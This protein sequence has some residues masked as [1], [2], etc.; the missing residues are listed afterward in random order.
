MQTELVLFIIFQILVIFHLFYP[1]ILSSFTF[2]RRR[3]KNI[4][5]PFIPE[6]DYAIIVTAYEQVN[7]IPAVVNSILH[8]NYKNYIIYVV[9]DKCDI[10]SLHFSDEKV[11]ILK[12]EATLANNIKSHFYAIENF[13]RQHDRLTIIDSDNLV[14]S[15]YL[16]ELNKTFS[17]GYD[18][19]QGIR[20]A[21]NLNTTYACLDAAGDLYY[22]YIDR[23]L[24]FEAGSSASLSGSG[25]AFSTKLYKAC[26]GNVMNSGAGFD[27]ILQ[28]EIVKRKQL[29]AFSE[30]AIVWD[31]K[32]AKA[33]QLVKQRARWINTWLK[34][35]ALGLKLTFNGIANFNRNQLLFGLMLLRP[36]LF[37]LLIVSFL[38]FV[39]NLFFMPVMAVVWILAA[40]IF[41]LIFFR[42]LSYFNA[43]KE[44][45]NSLAGVPKFI[46]YQILALFKVKKANEF[47]VATKHDE[48]LDSN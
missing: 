21:K 41:V 19:V 44:I 26:L 16:N 40:T 46:F 35:F 12:P 25:M 42:S 33:D 27:K 1:V 24:L 2:L 10:S 36:P 48:E 5:I 11:V 47:S 3:K 29:I 18:A 38:C 13:I 7:L 8:L 39:V 9:A 20:E 4:D 32:T 30:R 17:Q 14:D 37:I 31:E 15:E 28:Y 23:K 6:V 45:Y 34:F 22:R 43:R